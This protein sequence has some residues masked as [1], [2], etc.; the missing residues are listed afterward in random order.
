MKRILSFILLLITVLN[1]SGCGSFQLIK[2]PLEKSEYTELGI[3]SAENYEKGSAALYIYDMKIHNGK[4]YIGDGDYGENTGPVKVM[5]YDLATESWAVSGTLPDEAVTRFVVLGDKLVIPGTDPMDGWEY[6]NYY[7]LNDGEWETVRTIP[8][9]IHNFDMTE[10]DGKIF[11]ALGV[12]D[13]LYPVA[14]SN[15]GGKSFKLLTMRKDGTPIDTS[16]LESNRCYDLFVKDGGLYVTYMSYYKD[17]STP[18]FELYEY[19]GGKECFDFVKSLAGSIG[20]R[21]D[22]KVEIIRDH[23]IFKGAAYA[24]TGYLS[25]T[26]DMLNYTTLQFPNGETVWDVCVNED[27]LYVLCSLQNEDG[28]Y[29]ISVWQN[30]SGEMMDVKKRL[31]FDYDLPAVSFTVDGKD[32]YFG[33]SANLEPHEKNGTVLKVTVE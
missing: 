14:C 1:L 17:S 20:V 15:D 2:K 5:A 21:S 12:D 24:A 4:L 23:I 22:T 8:N 25:Y 18:I 26:E 16:G 30:D 7:V 11:A 19:N 31:W 10:F 28:S 13:G 9:G 6:G 32:F 29:T 3:P 27:K 33:M